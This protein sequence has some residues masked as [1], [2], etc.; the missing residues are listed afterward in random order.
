MLEIG[1][2]RFC[3]ATPCFLI[4]SSLLSAGALLAQDGGTV[5]KE[6]DLLNTALESAQEKTP[7]VEAKPAA[8]EPSA[9]VE[10]PAEPVPP[11]AVEEPAPAIETPAAEVKPEAVEPPVAVETPAEPVQ[12]VA[13]EEP[14]PA[15]ETP[16]PAAE[17]KPEAVESTPAVE[18]PAEPVPPVAVEEP[19]PAVETPAAEP[20]P[21]AVEP[22]VAVETPAEPVPPVAVEE[23][24][25]AVETPAAEPK[26]EAVEPPVAVEIPAEPVPPVAVEAPAPAVET[27]AAEPKPEAVE[28][29]PAVEMPAEPVPPVAVEVPAPAVETLVPAVEAQ[30]AAVE[31]PVAVETPV[32][33]V[34]PVAVESA[35]VETRTQ[36]VKTTRP[37]VM[38]ELPVES[39]P[40][41]ISDADAEHA[42]ERETKEI[43]AIRDLELGQKA[44]SYEAYQTAL[45]HFLGAEANLPD[46]PR[47][48]AARQKAN[49]GA[50]ICEYNI[51]MQKM[52]AGEM[53]GDQGALALAQRS[54]GRNRKFKAAG[55]LIERIKLRI[56][57]Q[58]ASAKTSVA[59]RRSSPDYIEKKEKIAKLLE[60]AVQHVRVREFTEAEAKLKMVLAV[61][62]FNQS[63]IALLKEVQESAAKI[64]L[65][66]REAMVKERLKMVTQTWNPRDYSNYAE[67]MSG[68][69]TA[70]PAPTPI[71]P[72]PEKILV[73]KMEAIT[74][75]EIAFREANIHD[76][77]EYLV[78]TAREGD[79][80]ETDPQKKG[81][82]IILK[83]REDSAAKNI[84]F[85]AKY[86]TLMEAIKIVTEVANLRYRIEKNVVIIVPADEADSAVVTRF[87]PIDP[88]VIKSLDATGGGAA[89]APAGGGA[90]PG[91]GGFVS[92]EASS[93]SATTVDLKDYFQRMGVKFPKEAYITYN[94]SISKI[95]HAN[96]EANLAVFEGILSQINVPSPQVE[97]EARFVD[98]TQDGL[99]EMGFEW[100]LTDNLEL[101]QKKGSA[102][103][104]ALARPRIQMNANNANGGF[105]KGLRFGTL[106]DA[107][108]GVA[109]SSSGENGSQLAIQSVLTTPELMMLVHAVEQKGNADLLSAPKVTTQPGEEAT[110]KVTTEYIYPTQ[111]RM[112]GGNT[113]LGGL[114]NNILNQVPIVLPEAFE[115]REVGVILTVR[116]EVSPD[117]NII[118]LTLSPD[119]VTD[120]VW[121]DYGY[122]LPDGSQ[123]PMKMPFFH[124]RTATTTV[125]V[126]DGATVVMG[127]MI[128]EDLRTA[129]DQIPALGSLPLIG[130]LFRSN[131]KK[132]SKRNLLIFVTAKLVDPAG[133]PIKEQSQQSEK[134]ISISTPAP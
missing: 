121:Y 10:T 80:T 59:K 125:R 49:E 71:G 47:T 86:V 118:T 38:G 130:R 12:P 72:T 104:P 116:P 124:R 56:E 98:I 27:P 132:T 79:S 75:R 54:Y 20:K 66:E 119:V 129:D 89:A 93:L 133:R 81:V 44:L 106:A 83:L 39:L 115:T 109:G 69:G 34:Q 100:R 91:E 14:A 4:L 35:P 87:Y 13:V 23:P 5:Q 134:T 46:N 29:S 120:P 28:P 92:M 123:V 111:Y 117:R 95:I 103:L 78:S 41:E 22:T 9:A 76:V 88:S 99:D 53:E 74:I 51:A 70:A 50:M 108:N 3:K 21:E 42:I 45:G 8:V 48:A 25:P 113:Q 6:E 7:A 31:P 24:A 68:A 60:M 61:D 33:A 127:G 85:T 16:V 122:T 64:K 65:D 131:Q 112:Q 58:R 90:A 97:I 40:R 2:M 107:G 77:V 32:E 19:A 94:P 105:T 82:N 101:L 43:Q 128:A 26:P 18:M 62:E 73:A 15:V 17:P 55:R 84:T 126:Y 1:K 110:V 114:N 63:A 96:T 57:E 30:P 36:P 67:P 37:N 11:V 102:A 52:E